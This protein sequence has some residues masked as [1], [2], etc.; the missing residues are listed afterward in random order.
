MH[1]AL[2]EERMYLFM[3]RPQG[4]VMV[5]AIAATGLEIAVELE[6]IEALMLGRILR[7]TV[8]PTKSGA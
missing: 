7:N 2:I 5:M 6:E 8:V 3:L 1:E 4:V